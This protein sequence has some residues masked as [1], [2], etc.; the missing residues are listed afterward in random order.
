MLW[1]SRE[2]SIG[3]SFA[4]YLAAIEGAGIVIVQ[5]RLNLIYSPPLRPSVFPDVPILPM[6]LFHI[7]LPI[8]HPL[9]D[10]AQRY[11]PKFAARYAQKSVFHRSMQFHRIHSTRQPREM[12][13]L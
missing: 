7:L 9:I 2:I 3:V 13:R 11:I 6:A 5:R 4:A 1:R 12:I 8:P 10:G